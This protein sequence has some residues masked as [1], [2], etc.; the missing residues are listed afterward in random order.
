MIIVLQVYSAA[1]IGRWP[2]EIVLVLPEPCS[3]YASLEGTESF[4]FSPAHMSTSPF[5]HPWITCPTPSW[6]WKGMDP[7][8]SRLKT[9]QN[10]S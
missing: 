3:P 4:L 2:P 9:T 1:S 8:R 10:K 6:N 5:S 7:G